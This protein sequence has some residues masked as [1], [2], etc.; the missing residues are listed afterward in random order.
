MKYRKLL[1]LLLC[2]LLAGCGKRAGGRDITLTVDGMVCPG[3]CDAPLVDGL[4]QGQGSF[5][6]QE[7]WRYEGE[8]EQG[9]FAR[10][11][12]TDLPVNMTLAGVESRG[13]YSGEVD[14]LR[15]Q[16]EGQFTVGEG[17]FTGSFAS[18]SP[19]DGVCESFPAAVTLC[20]EPIQGLYSGSVAAG[21]LHGSGS[22]AFSGR[23]VSRENGR[24]VEFEGNWDMG[25]VVGEGQ[26]TYEGFTVHTPTGDDRGA[27]TGSTLDGLPHGQGVFI[28]RN[29][30]DVDYRYEGEWTDGLWDGQGSLTYDSE[31]YYDRIGTFSQG[32]FTP[33]GKETLAAL[34]S[35]GVRFTVPEKTWEF[36]EGYPELFD[37][38]ATLPPYATCDYRLLWNLYQTYPV[39]SRDPEKYEGTWMCFYNERI[40]YRWREDSFGEDYRVTC[41]LAT[42]TIYTE[43]VLAIVFGNVDNLDT[44][45]SYNAYGVPLGMSTYTNVDGDEVPVMVMLVGA[46]TTY[47]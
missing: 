6:A 14:A 18:G 24:S 34:G 7:G 20:A 29:S 45:G 32:R 46:M 47:R 19:L 11:S 22:G 33:T 40:L 28:A 1:P 12:V 8:F 39:Y 16:G 9:Q 38:S 42:T 5:T 30:E 36:L 2:L 25:S 21:K 17:S 43:P 4:P 10:G 44:A 15:P 35:A 3:S 13:L 27:Y 37:R 23:F 26:L 31:L 41:L